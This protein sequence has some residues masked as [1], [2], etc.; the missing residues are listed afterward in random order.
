MTPQLSVLVVDDEPDLVR[1]VR[2]ILRLDG[3]QVDSCASLSE[4]LNRDN[5][6][7]YFAILLDRRLPDGTSDQILPQL[8]QRAS[9]SAIIVITA[10]ADLE[11][12][13]AA[14]HHGAEDFML[15]PVDPEQLRSRVKR[16]ADL[17]RTESELSHERAF[18]QI[19]LD[20]TRALILVL[21]RDGRILRI[22]RHLEDLCGYRENELAGQYVVEALAPK[23]YMEDAERHLRA[24]LAETYVQGTSH[25]M[26]TKSSRTC[27]VAWWNALLR[28][29]RGEIVEMV[30]AGLDRTDFN[31]LQQKLIQSERLAAIGEAMTGLAHESRNA[32]QR[33]QACLDLL[34]E[35]L[36]SQPESLELLDSIQR[37]QD[38]LHRLYEEVRAFAAPIQLRPTQCN[39]QNILQGE[40]R[41]IVAVHPDRDA[42]VEEHLNCADLSCLADPYAIGKVFRNILENSLQACSD[43]VAVDVLYSD[44]E[45]AGKPAVEVRLRDDGPGL[46]AQQREQ[47]FHSFFT[48]K[49]EGTGLGMAIAQ[50]IVQAHGG[51]IRVGDN[52]NQGA[53]FVVTLP[54]TQP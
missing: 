47:V 42:R 15:K 11:G 17:R 10:Y 21:D 23:H 51:L 3:Y 6:A 12:T 49:T 28:D 34:G 38:D 13:L 16:L 2:R 40:W 43:P 18:A 45:L 54:R 27:E 9:E 25:P 29:G 19:L 32:L 24:S 31:Q 20:T 46:D 26:K 35:Q 4:L 33:S 7:D 22:N 30:C 52:S 36:K 8:R 37:A 44:A 1:S 53:E 39:V 14:L 5:L 48:T 41:D 50:R